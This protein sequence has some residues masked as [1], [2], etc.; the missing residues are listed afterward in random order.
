M[1]WGRGTG[2]HKNL[3]VRVLCGS[4][5]YENFTEI[6]VISAKSTPGAAFEAYYKKFKSTGRRG[7]AANPVGTP[8]FCRLIGAYA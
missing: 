3:V 4:D 7:F 2:P 6:S 1:P 8:Q 5:P